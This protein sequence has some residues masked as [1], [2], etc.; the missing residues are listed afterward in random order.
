MTRHIVSY[1]LSVEQLDSYNMGE[2]MVL[3]IPMNP[4]FFPLGNPAKLIRDVSACLPDIDPSDIDDC[5]PGH[6]WCE[7]PLM[8]PHQRTTLEDVYGRTLSPQYAEQASLVTSIWV[9]VTSV[10]D[11]RANQT[12]GVFPDGSIRKGD[13]IY[14]PR[15]DHGIKNRE[16]LKRNSINPDYFVDSDFGGPQE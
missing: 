13:E 7:P 5:R 6:I 9:A 15:V 3:L 10:N 14:F 8:P 12:R 11:G 4:S 2:P 1:D 16:N